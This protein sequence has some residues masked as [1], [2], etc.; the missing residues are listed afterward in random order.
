MNY[1]GFSILLDLLLLNKLIYIH[2]E[3]FL[4][5]NSQTL[6]ILK[7]HLHFVKYCA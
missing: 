5:I 7:I 6:K 3:T 4:V 2:E 1:T